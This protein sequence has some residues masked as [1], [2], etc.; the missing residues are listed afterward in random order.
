MNNISKSFGPVCVLDDVSIKLN[1]GEVLGL[2]GENG[3]G[4]STLVKILCGIYAKDQGE[5]L[6][7]GDP[8]RIRTAQQAQAIGISTI[9]QEL[10]LIPDMNAIENIFVNRE[11]CV[12]KANIFAPLRYTE[13]KKKAEMILRDILH[14]SI[15]VE[16]PLR[17]LTLAQKQMVEIAR[18][19]YADAQVII[20]D[21]PTAALE[22]AERKQLFSVIRNLKANGRSVIFI[23]HHLDEICEICDRIDILRDGKLVAE[24]ETKEFSITK[25]IHEMIGKTLQQQYPKE[26]VDIGR[27]MLR[28]QGL[29]K[30]GFFEN[31][32]FVLHEGEILGIVGLEGCGKNEVIRSLFG[33]TKYDCGE[34]FFHGKKIEPSKIKDAMSH[35]IA[36]VPAE[37]KIEGLFLK[38]DIAW[39]TT[40][41]SIDK[42]IH[43][44]TISRKEEIRF[45]ED[46]MKQMGIRAKGY[47]QNIALLSGGN[48][49]K[50]ILSRW[51][52]TDAEIF[53]LEDPTR[54]IDVNA[55]TI[56]Y[57]TI[58]NCVRQ[59]K[60]VI[61]VSSSEDEVLGIC[62]QII[63]MR[64]GKISAVLNAKE[65]NTAEIKK[66]SMKESEGISNYE[67]VEL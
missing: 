4:K 24:G 25:I 45:T 44:G 2:I 41:A 37:R 5:I 54:G 58:G 29:T 46:F 8:V 55:K 6:W 63:V 49:Q 14:V 1:R 26:K 12:G 66:Y 48:Q 40:I 3:A 7:N 19:V 50:V 9:Y 64:T 47:G 62:D 13:E 21:E 28:V 42:V 59:K 61:F 36:F 16:K 10:S 23:S 17:F 52:M 11:L 39:N 60:S 31:V 57:S 35:G 15:D 56:V 67:K 32:S 18:T 65:T 38:Q 27:E 22:E 53:L 33:S 43:N 34:I 20:M 30:N 51:I